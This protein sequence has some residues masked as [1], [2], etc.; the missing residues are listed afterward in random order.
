MWLLYNLVPYLFD[1]EMYED[2]ATKIR[3]LIRLD[4]GIF[5]NRKKIDLNRVKQDWKKKK[6]E[7]GVIL[8]QT[9][10]LDS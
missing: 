8:K 10:H 1:M 4:R 2:V 6:V 7:Q 5:F 3:W 9:D